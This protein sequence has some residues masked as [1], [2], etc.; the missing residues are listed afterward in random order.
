MSTKEYRTISEARGG[1]LV[2]Q[3]RPTSLGIIR[4]VFPAIHAPI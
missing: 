3:R 1:L 2:R 4:P